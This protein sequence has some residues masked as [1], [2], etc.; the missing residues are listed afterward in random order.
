MLY[1]ILCSDMWNCVLF[2]DNFVIRL[3]LCDSEM[4]VAEANNVC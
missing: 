2:A 4:H 1:V 3:L